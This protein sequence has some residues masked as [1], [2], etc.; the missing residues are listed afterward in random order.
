[1]SW[2][3]P[4]EWGCLRRPPRKTF[5]LCKSRFVLWASSTCCQVGLSQDHSGK[6]LLSTSHFFPVISVLAKLTPDFD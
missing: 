3:V 1:M 4:V 2:C 5:F 6:G